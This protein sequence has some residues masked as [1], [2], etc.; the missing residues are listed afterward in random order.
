[1][2]IIPTVYKSR[3]SKI[4]S[5]TKMIIKN[6]EEEIDDVSMDLNELIRKRTN[7]QMDWEE[8]DYEMTDLNQRLINSDY[9]ILNVHNELNLLIEKKNELEEPLLAKKMINKIITKGEQMFQEKI[10]DY[11]KELVSCLA[12]DITYYTHDTKVDK[13]DRYNNII[14]RT[15]T[16]IHYKAHYTSRRGR[17]MM[18]FVK[19]CQNVKTYRDGKTVL[20]NYE[21]TINNKSKTYEKNPFINIESWYDVEEYDQVF[22]F[23][24]VLVPFALYINVVNSKLWNEKNFGKQSDYNDEQFYSYDFNY[25]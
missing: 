11:V 25:Y 8:L 7:M 15:T 23:D 22:Y 5:N 12:S 19:C 21:I 3:I 14:S 16:S 24:K 20:C 18:L 13:Y 9:Q 2:Y 6:L 10:P 1:M 17:Y 4:M